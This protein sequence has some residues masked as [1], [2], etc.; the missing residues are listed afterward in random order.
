MRSGSRQARARETP[1]FILSNQKGIKTMTYANDYA[2]SSPDD[3]DEERGAAD[4]GMITHVP[5]DH[6]SRQSM[7]APAELQRLTPDATPSYAA[8]TVQRVQPLP[9]RDIDDPSLQRAP[10]AEDLRPVTDPGPP[11]APMQGGQ[12]LARVPSSQADGQGSPRVAPPAQASGDPGQVTS[13]LIGRR[14]QEYAQTQR[15]GSLDL[16]RVAP[17]AQATSDPNQ[18]FSDLIGRRV[19]EY[20]QAQRASSPPPIQPRDSGRLQRAEMQASQARSDIASGTPEEA[21]TALSV[22]GVPQTVQNAVL[23]GPNQQALKQKRDQGPPAGEKGFLG[24]LKEMGKGALLGIETGRGAIPGAIVGVADPDELERERFYSQT[25]PRAEKLAASEAAQQQ[26]ELRRAGEAAGQTGIYP[27]TGEQTYAA[28]IGEGRTALLMIKLIL[29][30][31]DKQ[32]LL[33]QGN[34]RLAYLGK[35]VEDAETNN[36][37]HNIMRAAQFAGRQIS[38]EENEFIRKTTGVTLPEKFD[39]QADYLRQDENGRWILFN[40]SKSEPG[41]VTV[42][43][44]GVKG[45]RGR[46]PPARSA[47]SLVPYKGQMHKIISVNKDGSY[48]LDPNPVKAIRR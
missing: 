4:P 25:L 1:E 26:E 23:D 29:S 41:K 47:G 33:R 38:P 36:R 19:Q 13:D 45:A 48:V 5:S 40:A 15:G 8:A 34:V 2:S 42:T 3:F 22:L 35:R 20:A 10:G 7:P 31:Q 43:D 14:I 18:V 11:P 44:T 6:P 12:D 16:Q 39:P 9:A 37:V 27:L 21:K 24:R 46:R 17:A 30:E 28:K 32:E